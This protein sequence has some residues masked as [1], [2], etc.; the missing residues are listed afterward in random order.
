MPTGVILSGDWLKL[1]SKSCRKWHTTLRFL[2]NP[3]SHVCRTISHLE[4]LP[5]LNSFCHFLFPPVYAVPSLPHWPVFA[6]HPLS[7]THTRSF[8]VYYNLL[9]VGRDRGQNGSQPWQFKSENYSLMVPKLCTDTLGCCRK[10]TVVMQDNLNFQRKRSDI[11]LFV[12]H[13]TGC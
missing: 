8:Q 10:L 4:L 2:Q 6:T 9:E 11:Q 13:H 5:L 12:R 1:H 3:S 7:G